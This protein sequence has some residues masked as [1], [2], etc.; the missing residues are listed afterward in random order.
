MIVALDTAIQEVYHFCFKVLHW[1][2]SHSQL[3]SPQRAKYLF[4]N[5]KLRSCLS[6]NWRTFYLVMCTFSVLEHDPVL[7]VLE[8]TS[9]KAGSVFPRPRQFVL[10]SHWRHVIVCD[11]NFWQEEGGFRI[12]ST[13]SQSPQACHHWVGSLLIAGNILTFSS[14]PARC[15]LSLQSL[16]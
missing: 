6:N 4:T 13:F 16:L 8:N 11:L 15:S 3:S 1:T 10:G 7:P 5:Q 2:W 12:S 9:W 14:S